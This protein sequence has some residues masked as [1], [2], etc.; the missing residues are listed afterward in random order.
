MVGI[1]GG[2]TVEKKSHFFPLPLFFSIS[3]SL[4]L[5]LS[6]SPLPLRPSLAVVESEIFG[7]E[8]SRVASDIESPSPPALFFPDRGD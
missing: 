3:L 4:S 7:E 5:S 8:K 6:L 2:N 1:Q